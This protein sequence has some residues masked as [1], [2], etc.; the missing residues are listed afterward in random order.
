MKKIQITLFFLLAYSLQSW[1]VN[2]QVSGLMYLEL[3]GVYVETGT[4]NGQPYFVK[5]SVGGMS[6]AI[7]YDGCCQWSIGPEINPGSIDWIDYSYEAG[8]PP[9]TGWMSVIVAPEVKSFTYQASNFV[10]NISN[11]GSV[12]GKVLISYNKFGG[13]KLSGTNGE[14]FLTANKATVSNIPSGLTATLIRKSD[15]TLLFTLAGNALNHSNANN[16]TDLTITLNNSALESNDVSDAIGS[17]KADLKINFRKIITVAASGADYSTIAAALAAS[18]PYDV[19]KIAEGVY[20][21]YNLTINHALS[22]FGEGAS[23]TIIQAAASSGI[24]SNRVFTNNTN[25]TVEFNGLTVQNGYL[26]TKN[27]YG[28]GIY[29]GNLIVKN[30]IFK[31]NVCKSTS[32]AA[33]IGGAIFCYSLTLINSIVSGNSTVGGH[34]KGGA[35]YVATFKCY[36][37]SIF[38]N[39][40]KSVVEYEVTGGAVYM[41]NGEIVNS[42]IFNNLA[43]N[44]FNANNV[45][46]GGVFCASSSKIVNSTI[47]G[48][49]ATNGAGL[50]AGI[51]SALIN[52]IVYGNIGDDTK[53]R[54]DGHNNIVGANSLVNFY[55][56]SSNI[57]SNDPLLGILADNGGATQ[58]IALQ[59]GSPAIDAGTAGDDIPKRD[60]RNL[61]ANGIRDIGAYEY[62]ALLC[63]VPQ[64][65]VQPQDL[66]LCLGDSVHLFSEAKGDSLNYQMYISADKVNFVSPIPQSSNYF[67]GKVYESDLAYTG[68]YFVF[69]ASNGC[70]VDTSDFALFNINY[71]D[72]TVELNSTTLT[73]VATDV[74]YQWINCDDNSTIIDGATFQSFTPTVSGNYAVIMDDHKCSQDTSACQY[75]EVQLTGLDHLGAANIAIYPNPATDNVTVAFT[76]SVTG[77][78]AIVDIHGNIVS[79]TA[80]S[81]NKTTIST[82]DLASGVYV[83]KIATDKGVYVKQLAIR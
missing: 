83:V 6:Y 31:D 22:I 12:D 79:A 51:P 68:S 37:S 11:D 17:E 72:P 74:T 23:K 8:Y 40:A 66:N 19:V 69:T 65:T 60:Q 48:N 2:L 78:V 80:I 52:C 56:T 58:T 44:T 67:D 15:S 28:G 27:P 64:F 75:V 49:T 36:N 18:A 38:N 9:L 59:A 26:F 61:Y 82:A 47:T 4:Q 25:D 77:T 46:G 30:C 35:I 41:D 29:G 16:V 57:S 55:N 14:N 34:S 32:N 50:F 54:F 1:A 5:S 39:S 42:T 62:S 43:I 53:G 7:G 21:E 20:T 3:N 70:G 13:D 33:N 73:A 24:A 71:V 81:S 63:V 45:R 10:E 76:E